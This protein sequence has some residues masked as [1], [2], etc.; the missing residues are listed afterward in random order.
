VKAFND[1]I[2]ARARAMRH[3]FETRPP[4]AGKD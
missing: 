3:L 1:F 4:R 2:A